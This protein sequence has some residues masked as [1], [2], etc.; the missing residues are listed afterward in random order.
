MPQHLI[1][2]GFMAAGK[3]TLGQQA[4]KALQWP[5]LDLD[6]WIEQQARRSITE[7]FAAEG[8][9]AFRAREKEA[10]LHLDDLTKPHVVATGGGLP[11]QGDHMQQLLQRGKVVYLK[12]A[13]E[14]LLSRLLAMREHRPML[15]QVSAEDLPAHIDELLSQREDFYGQAHVT[16]SD[17]N[18]TAENLQQA[19]T[20]F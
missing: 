9:L 20:S 11:C 10:I 8:E 18:L 1:L 19:A 14:V 13:R 7:I 5:F 15:S 2:I 12:P 16:L 6:Q 3:T 4:A 17:E